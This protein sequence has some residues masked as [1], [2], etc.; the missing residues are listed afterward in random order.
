MITS[1][2]PTYEIGWNVL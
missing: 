1:E 2:T